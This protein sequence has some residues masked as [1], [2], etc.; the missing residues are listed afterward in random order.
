MSSNGRY[1][2]FAS[3]A[4]NL[5]GGDTNNVSDIFVRD[6]VTRLTT[7]VSIATSGAQ[8]NGP[9]Y[10]PAISADGRYVAFESEAT[11][12]VSGDTN[13]TSDIFVRDLWSKT[14]T[15]VSIANGAAGTE[16]NG[17]SFD[18]SIS[19]DGRFVAY[20]SEATNLVAGDNNNALDVFVRDRTGSTT[21]RVS[22]ATGAAGAPGNADSAHPCISGNGQFVA[23]ISLSGNL[24]TGDTN[25]SFDV[26][27]RDLTA[28][29]TSRVSIGTG[30]AGAQANRDSWQPF[31]S[32]DGHY[33]VFAS[34][35]TNLV[36]GD[37]NRVADIFLR[38]RTLNTT[39]RVSLD[40]SN[41]QGDGPSYNP[42]ISNDGRY[43][44]FESYA[45]LEALDFNNAPDIYVRDRTT[46]QTSL[47]SIA[48][49][50]VRGNSDSLRPAM[51]TDGRYVAFESFATNLV[52]G[53]NNTS[54]DIFVRDRGVGTSPPY[55]LIYPS[56]AMSEVEEIEATG[57]VQGTEEMKE[58]EEAEQP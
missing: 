21:K 27:V 14:T 20:V 47:V 49:S 4:P 35:A 3:D 22:I 9:S 23:F 42:V 38:D 16:G 41:F 7:R 30:A 48:T 45:A 50:T 2:A 24:V 18:P 28:N 46:S 6:R 29:T 5:V 10:N 43:V 15:R 53:D 55:P 56:E 12:L 31:I 34:D 26:F 32:N 52:N 36:G 17:A 13:N 19:A 44:A 25:N 54:W 8:G 33:V 11:N 40:I 58:P 51:S 1:I 37:T 57:D 39:S